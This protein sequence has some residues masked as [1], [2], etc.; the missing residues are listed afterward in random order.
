[1]VDWVFGG[2]VDSVPNPN[3]TLLS[4][5]NTDRSGL[6]WPD[7]AKYVT[8]GKAAYT[9]MGDWTAGAFK[10][11]GLVDGKDYNGV[12]I[13]AIGLTRA[14]ATLQEERVRQRDQ[15]SSFCD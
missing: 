5:A 15:R 4:Y 6:D 14:L 13:P 3:E 12:T 10:E 8:D 2:G 7:A 11:Q 9:V 1:M